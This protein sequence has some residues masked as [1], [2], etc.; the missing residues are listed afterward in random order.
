MCFDHDARPPIEPIAGASLDSGPETLA[1]AADGAA[2]R[3]FIARP[4]TPTGAGILILP[5][6]RGLHPYYEELAL[7]YAEHGIAAVAIDYFGR[8]AGQEPRGADFDHMPHVTAATW[9]Q[10]E[11][12]I[13]AGMARLR[14]E[15]GVHAAFAT[16]FCMGGRLAFV[17]ATLG[18]GLAGVI[19]YYGWPTGPS[20]NGTPAPADI[21]DRFGCDV[22]SIWGGAD[23]GLPATVRDA[24]S[25]ALDA[26]G[27]PHR[28]L[29][30]EG[31]PHS[32]FDRK[33]VD[34]A[35]ASAGAWAATLDFIR[36]HTA[37]LPI[38]G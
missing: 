27:V 21:A 35:E 26:A 12:D 17:S 36:R 13:R 7:R 16:G 25:A 1:S 30:Y 2:F 10:L 15:A 28:S 33:A 19:G 5:D 23:E 37:G 34:F 9:P 22:L 8:T 31:A 20:R 24:F 38:A 3:A 4:T 18:L 32:F 11:G 14:E 6:V 29:V